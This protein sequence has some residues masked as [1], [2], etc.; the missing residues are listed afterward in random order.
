MI[1]DRRD[2]QRWSDTRTIDVA[3]AG[4]VAALSC[5]LI[6]VVGGT[7]LIDG[8]PLSCA[9]ATAAAAVLVIRRRHP[10]VC[11]TAALLATFASDERTP[12]IVALYS[13]G[14]YGG[15][16]R[17]PTVVGTASLYFTTRCFVGTAASSLQE[18]GYGVAVDIF[19]PALMG[20]LLRKERSLQ[21]LLR[22][23]LRHTE[24]TAEH[25]A[26]FAALE[27][28]TRLA[29]DIHDNVGHQTSVLVLH[30]GCLQQVP[31]L[32]PPARAVAERITDTAIA[33][34]HELRAVISVLHDEDADGRPARRQL[35]CAEFLPV[36]VRNME[37]AGM[38]IT[39]RVRGTRRELS[40]GADAVLHRVSREALT[41]AAKHAPGAPV[42]VTLEFTAAA[43]SL[44]VDNG[45]SSAAGRAR[46]SGGLG[47]RGLREALTAEGGRLEAGALPDGGYRLRAVL[48]CTGSR[49]DQGS[50]ND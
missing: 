48:D 12:L 42:T 33:V 50:Q 29:Y 8:Y 32:P 38:D 22:D 9:A 49:I 44:S 37:V 34:M 10:I 14:Q 46:D 41:N 30:A 40:S 36:L 24:L 1:S 20:E 5:V 19:L 28:R 23:R 16:M 4:A 47:L 13:L 21:A 17:W 18:L 6:T 27:E 43:V 45:P 26:R 25:A 39:Y 15:R 7:G 2:R 3:L 11:V 35:P 31:D